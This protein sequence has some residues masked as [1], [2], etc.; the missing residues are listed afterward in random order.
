MSDIELLSI[1]ENYLKGELSE[2]ERIRFEMLRHDNATVDNRVKEHELFTNHLKQYGERVEFENLLNSIHQEIDVHALKE[3]LVDHP[4]LIVRIWRNHHS[5]IALAA[6][7]AL[8]TVLGT[9]FFEGL[10]R[11]Q[12]QEQKVTNLMHAFENVKHSNDENTKTINHLK[13]SIAPSNYKGIGTGFAISSDGYIVTNFHV[14][15]GVDSVYIQNSDGDAYHAKVV[16]TNPLYDIAVLKITDPSFKS[17]GPLPY[18]FKRGHTDLGEDVFTLGYSKD[19]A[20]CSKG[21]LS[22]GNGFKGDSIKYQL[23]MDVDYGNSGGPVLDSKGNVIGVISSKQ[24]LSD[25]VSF[26]VKSSYLIK[27]IKSIP[28]DS[29]NGGLSLASK[30]NMANLSRPQQINKLQN[31][32]FMVKV[33]NN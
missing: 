31:Y 23:S 26:A 18:G 2:D 17:L 3:E 22:S 4:S 32:V 16:S 21:Y 13:A 28:A 9:L 29:V 20:V 11:S 6:S 33:Y 1:I 27:A 30:G 14:V 19:D 7:I 25:G 24:L 5:K 10:L 8:F 12:E 15:N